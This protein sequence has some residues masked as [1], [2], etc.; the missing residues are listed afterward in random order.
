MQPALNKLAIALLGAALI[1]LTLDQMVTARSVNTEKVGAFLRTSLL[2]ADIGSKLLSLQFQHG[3]ATMPNVLV[4]KLRIQPLDGN[5]C[6]P[7]IAEDFLGMSFNI[8]DEFVQSEFRNRL[9][10]CSE[11]PTHGPQ[12]R[13]PP[14][15]HPR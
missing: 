11:I 12:R 9:I 14:L 10:D 2:F 4:L 8:L 5:S 3:I 13:R 7:I 1:A 15:R 6:A